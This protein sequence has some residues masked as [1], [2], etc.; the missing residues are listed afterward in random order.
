MQFK[1]SYQLK[2]PGDKAMRPEHAMLREKSSVILNIFPWSNLFRTCWK[3]YFQCLALQG[4]HNVLP[5]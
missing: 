4:Y 1:C 5:Y 2:L 3:Q